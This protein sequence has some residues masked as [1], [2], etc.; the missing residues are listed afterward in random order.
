MP[1]LKRFVSTLTIGAAL[2]TG[3]VG[4]GAVATTT[5]ADAA[6][7][8]SLPSGGD[9]RDYARNRNRAYNRNWSPSRAWARNWNR[10]LARS[11][12]RNWARHFNRSH[13]RSHNTNRQAQT[14]NIRLIFPNSMGGPVTATSNSDSLSRTRTPKA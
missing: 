7:V 6:T 2:T 9:Y 12:A 10:S 1:K 3:M 14:V 5:G 13:S 4:L 8:M 11:W